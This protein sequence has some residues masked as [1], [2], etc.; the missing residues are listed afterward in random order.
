M[1]EIIHL[2]SCCGITREMAMSPSEY[3]FA[4]GTVCRCNRCHKPM[5]YKGTKP[6]CTTG[7]CSTTWKP[8]KTAIAIIAALIVI[9]PANAASPLSDYLLQPNDQLESHWFTHG[10]CEHPVLG[11]DFILRITPAAKRFGLD[12]FTFD[13]E[14]LITLTVTNGTDEQP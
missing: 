12:K 7:V 10:I 1:Q 13:D 11:K 9:Q 6:I 8:V 3:R 2:Y 4:T 5:F 14:T